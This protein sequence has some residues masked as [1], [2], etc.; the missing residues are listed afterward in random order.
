MAIKYIDPKPEPDPQPI[1][2]GDLKPGESVQ[3]ELR[4]SLAKASIQFV[5]LD[6]KDSVVKLDRETKES[7]I[8][9]LSDLKMQIEEAQ[10]RLDEIPP[11]PDDKE[12]LEWARNNFPAMNYSAEIAMLQKVIDD[13]TDL[14]A[15]AGG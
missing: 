7:K 9:S 8:Y 1:D 14:I 13:N 15:Q 2:A 12:L 5:I 4:S 11:M 6:D 3:V 10:K